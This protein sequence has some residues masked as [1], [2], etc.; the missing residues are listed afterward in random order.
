M[1]EASADFDLALKSLKAHSRC[2]LRRQR[3]HHDGSPERTISREKDARH[4]TATQLPLDIESIGETGVKLLE[5]FHDLDE[6]DAYS[7]PDW[8][9][10]PS[11]A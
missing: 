1:L 9:D 4:R 11:Y 6:F 10:A 3:L 5:E 8:W 7:M 2:E